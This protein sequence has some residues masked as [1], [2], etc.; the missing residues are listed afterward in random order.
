[1]LARSYRLRSAADIARVY[2]RG[3]YGASGGVLS[4]K[5]ARSGRPASRAVVVVAK[6]ISKRAVVRNRIRRRL[7]ELLRS[8][9]TTVEPGYDIVVSVHSDISELTSPVLAEHLTK[10]LRRAGV[11][12][13]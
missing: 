1:V 8:T 2:R 5:A 10:A 12:G 9:W 13:G 3:T 11:L 7:I 4:V 6:K